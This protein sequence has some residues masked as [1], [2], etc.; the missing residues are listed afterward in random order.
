MFMKRLTLDEIKMTSDLKALDEEYQQV[1]KEYSEDMSKWRKV[2]AW[3]SQSGMGDRDVEIIEAVCKQKLSDSGKRHAALLNKIHGIK[4]QVTA[5]SHTALEDKLKAILAEPLK[6]EKEEKV[7]TSA[8]ERATERERR[9]AEARAITK[10]KKENE[11]KKAIL[12]A[13]LESVDNRA[14]AIMQVENRALETGKYAPYGEEISKEEWEQLVEDTRELH[15]ERSKRADTR[16]R[17][18]LGIKEEEDPAFADR[19]DEDVE[20]V[21]RELEDEDK[22][23]GE[24]K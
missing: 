24:K 17:K 8:S 22:D 21:N 6:K 16:K 4:M 18:E 2:A 11:N 1:S 14:F 9:K 15:E 19:Q 5:S 7:V 10:Q 3:R 20:R 13:Y 12:I 23:E